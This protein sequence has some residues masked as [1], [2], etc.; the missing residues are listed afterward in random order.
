[1]NDTKEGS[2][3]SGHYFLG[4]NI[5]DGKPIFLNGAIHTLC[6]IVGVA[7]SADEAELRSLFLNTQET[8]KLR[9]SLQELGHTQPPTRIHTENTAATGIIH[10][11]IKQHQSCAMNMSS[12]RTISKQDDRTINVSWHHWR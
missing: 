9:I 5:K 2:T 7:A 4:N 11:K 6:K 12:F 10:K 8:V 1:M 3:T